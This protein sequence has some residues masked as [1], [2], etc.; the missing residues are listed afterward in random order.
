MPLQ[1]NHTEEEA[2]VLKAVWD[3]IQ[4]T[5][6][7]ALFCKF[8]NP[9]DVTLMPNTGTDLRLFNI[10]VGDFLSTPKHGTLG[11]KGVPQGAVGSERTYLAYLRRIVANPQLRPGAEALI[12]EPVGRFAAW[13]DA[14]FTVERVWLSNVSI[15]ID[16]TVT[17][18]DAI[19]I[20]RNIA[21]HNFS[22]LETDVHRI[23]KIMEA[24]GR[25]VSEEEAYLLLPDFYEW[26]HTNIFAY[27]TSH[28]GEM[29]NGIH[30]GHLP[31][32]TP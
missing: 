6:N 11:P 15:E 13:L 2:I 28:I 4:G 19:K 9:S 24:N 12:G 32:P 8:S 26:F 10:L 1:Y 7:Y 27:H 17:R 18:L 5:V 3:Q 31:L 25:A 22:R 30:L 14:R 23:R 21:K 29:L 16:L 20:C